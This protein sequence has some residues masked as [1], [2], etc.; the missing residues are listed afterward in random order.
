MSPLDDLNCLHTNFAGIA[1]DQYI[2]CYKDSKNRVL[3]KRYYPNDMRIQ[4]CLQKCHQGGFTYA[5]LQVML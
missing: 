2:G 4:A 3:P 5:G 1:D